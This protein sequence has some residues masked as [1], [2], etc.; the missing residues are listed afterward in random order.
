MQRLVAEFPDKFGLTVSH[1]TRRPKEHEVRGPLAVLLRAIW[2]S[3]HLAVCTH[4][5][6]ASGSFFALLETR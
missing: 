2:T 1:T 6:A 4:A 5:V 3:M